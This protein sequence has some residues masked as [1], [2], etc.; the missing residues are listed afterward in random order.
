MSSNSGEVISLLANQQAHSG[1]PASGQAFS[2]VYLRPPDALEA[3]RHYMA[4]VERGN[5][6][7]AYNALGLLYEKGIGL[8]MQDPTSPE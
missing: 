5:D 2:F 7:E 1:A 4:A 8:D 6:V 3:C